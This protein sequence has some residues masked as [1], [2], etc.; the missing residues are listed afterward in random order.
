MGNKNILTKKNTP[1]IDE[2]PEKK[3]DQYQKAFTECDRIT[4]CKWALKY[5]IGGALTAI[6]TIRIVWLADWILPTEIVFFI[7]VYLLVGILVCEWNKQHAV[8][9][10]GRWNL[11]RW[12][13]QAYWWLWWPYFL[14]HAVMKRF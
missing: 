1:V 10:D 13:R 2:P 5:I 14:W 6:V 12:V 4:Q 3:Q 8:Q 9:L 7:Q 11:R